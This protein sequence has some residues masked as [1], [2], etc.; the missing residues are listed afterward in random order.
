MWFMAEP[1]RGCIYKDGYFILFNSFLL[2]QNMFI[3]VCLF[4]FL[5]YNQVKNSALTDNFSC[6]T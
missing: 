3:L 2:K 5:Y 1:M 4:V 6:V